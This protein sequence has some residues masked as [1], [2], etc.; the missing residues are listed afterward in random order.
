MQWLTWADLKSH[1][2]ECMNAIKKTFKISFAT[3]CFLWSQSVY[4]HILSTEQSISSYHV[5]MDGNPSICPTSWNTYALLSCNVSLQHMNSSSLSLPPA[6]YK[7]TAPTAWQLPTFQFQ[8]EGG[9]AS[10]AMCVCPNLIA[11]HININVSTEHISLI[12]LAS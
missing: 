3:F 1:R 2:S 10:P 9:M 11:N 5:I 6:R 4:I 12:F 7:S 8:P